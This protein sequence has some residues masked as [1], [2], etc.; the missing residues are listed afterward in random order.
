[1]Q[2]GLNGSFTF[3]EVKKV[4]DLARNAGNELR[5]KVVG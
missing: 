5:P 3:D 1:M 4:I 2:K